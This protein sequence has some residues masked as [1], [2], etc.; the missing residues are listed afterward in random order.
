MSLDGHICLF[1]PIL[2]EPQE[3]EERKKRHKIPREE[4]DLEAQFHGFSLKILEELEDSSHEDHSSNIVL[5]CYTLFLDF[6]FCIEFVIVDL[7]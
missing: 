6:R 1:W 7:S 2:G 3:E 4:G 5:P